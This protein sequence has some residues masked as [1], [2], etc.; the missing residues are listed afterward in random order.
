MK[1]IMKS[2]TILVIGVVSQI[3]TD[4][5]AVNEGPHLD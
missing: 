5:L 4:L 3:V 1:H 2:I